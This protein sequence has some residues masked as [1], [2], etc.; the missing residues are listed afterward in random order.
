MEQILFKIK[1]NNIRTCSRHFTENMLYFVD[2]GKKNFHCGVGLSYLLLHL[3][4]EIGNLGYMKR[5]VI[6][7]QCEVIFKL[8]VRNRGHNLSTEI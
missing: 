5:T 2:M 8:A 4:A 3:K 7:P 1:T 6:Y